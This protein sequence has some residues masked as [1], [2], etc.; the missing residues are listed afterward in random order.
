[1]DQSPVVPG[2]D[3]SGVTQ[4]NAY[5]GST[6][7]MRPHRP[8]RIHHGWVDDVAVFD[9]ALTSTQIGLLASGKARR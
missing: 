8:L 3:L 6:G 5:I 4:E 9:G 7:A 2:Y 1:M